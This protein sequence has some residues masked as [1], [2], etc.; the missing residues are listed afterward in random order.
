MH[1]G[2]SKVMH[3]AYINL[4]QPSNFQAEAN[5][6]NNLIAFHHGIREN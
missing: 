4:T 5:N 3:D 6:D 2:V 1:N